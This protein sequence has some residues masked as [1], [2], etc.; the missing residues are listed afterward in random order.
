MM[1]YELIRSNRKTLGLEVRRDGRVLVRAPMKV[2]Q[3][4]ITAFVQSHEPWIREALARQEQRRA[5]HPE[6]T[7]EEIAHLKAKAKELLPQKAAAF[8][9][10]MGLVYSGITITSARTRFGSCSPQNRLCFS[11]RLMM[12]P[13]A[14][15]DYVVVHELAH[16]VH[17]NHGPAFHQLVASILPDHR[18]RRA[19]LKE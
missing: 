6:P 19:L 15:I 17:R 11:W 1:D 3:K 4:Q 8:A 2:S 13:E 9:Q 14:A 5:A 7:E 12:Y 18:E 10:K 16:I